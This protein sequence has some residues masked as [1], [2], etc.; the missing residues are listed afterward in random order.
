MIK[1]LND[2]LAKPAADKRMIFI[3]VNTPTAL[4][5]NGMPDWLEPAMKRLEEYERNERPENATAYVWLTNID[6]HRHPDSSPNLAASPF[7]LGMTDFSRPGMIRVTDA[8]LQREKHRDAHAIGHALQ[9][10]SR[11]PATFDGKMPSES[12]GD[13]NEKITIGE[14]YFFADVGENGTLGTV[15]S[16]FVDE[17]KKE[18]YVGLHNGVITRGPISD[19]LLADYKEFGDACFGKASGPTIKQPKN[20]LEWF[21]W[22]MEAYKDAPRVNMIGFLTPGSEQAELEKLSDEELRMRYCEAHV[23]ALRNMSTKAI[24]AGSPAADSSHKAP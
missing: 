13:P 21:T 12:I 7:G 15:T 3:D 17:E 2:A 4:A 18:L 6:F 19:E 9:T 20:E 8:Y 22:F 10:L 24:P 1:H 5:T 16:V 14:T 11:F 23:A